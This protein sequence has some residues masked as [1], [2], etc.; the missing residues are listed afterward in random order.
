M[1]ARPSAETAKLNLTPIQMQCI[2]AEVEREYTTKQKIWKRRMLLAVCLAL[3]DLYNFGDKRLGFVIQAI[4]D[5]A[6]DYAG[7]AYPTHAAEIAAIDADTDKMADLMQAELLS[8]R[9]LHMK[10]DT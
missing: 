3:N 7:Q 1:K 5:I 10:F 2:R 9:G 6:S 8:R 4:D